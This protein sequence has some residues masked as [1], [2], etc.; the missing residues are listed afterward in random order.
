[1]HYS[2]F[3]AILLS[4]VLVLSINA[5][6][7]Q[8]QNLN[9]AYIGIKKKELKKRYKHLAMMPVVAAPV[10]EM[11]ENLRAMVS[12]AVIKK[13]TKSKFKLVAPAETQAIKSQ[14]SSLY[15]GELSPKVKATISEHTR[16]EILFQHPVDGL[17]SV[18]VR[19]VAAPFLKD[20]AEWGGTSQK[21]K[22][23]GDGF[24]GTIMGKDYGGHV[25]ASAVTM[26]ITDRA[27]NVVYN[28]MGGIEV[29]MERNGEQLEALPASSFWQ[30]PKRVEKA[31]K[32]A[33]KPI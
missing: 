23:K 29:L 10:L 6:A 21:I 1:M 28:W 32:Y 31:V 26:R 27:G 15:S 5:S 24:F 8:A 3:K 33:L 16:R 19:P 11:P 25:A 9:D 18:E 4:A 12:D 14:F 22:H 20:K 7:T 30:K 13:L 2:T 17:V